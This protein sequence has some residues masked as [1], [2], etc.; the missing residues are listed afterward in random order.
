MGALSNIRVTKAG[1]HEYAG[2]ARTR[3]GYPKIKD[4]PKYWA[5]HRLAWTKY[6]GP[7][8]DG[9]WVLHKC[10][11]RLC[12]NTEHLFIGTRQ[13]NVDDMHAKGRA[14]KASGERH[15]HARFSDA[16]VQRMRELHRSGVMQIDIA[17]MYDTYQ[18][19]VGNIVRGNSRRAQPSP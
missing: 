3:G 7:I 4:G 19:V 5:G 13:D 15:P 17:E 6:V 10:D 2:R 18:G 14:R 9:M 8:P 11:N 1:C 12:M 16:D